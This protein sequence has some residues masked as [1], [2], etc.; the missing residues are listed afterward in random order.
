M[1]QN[2]LGIDLSKEWLDI[3]DPRSG[4]DSRCANSPTA[5]RRFLSRLGP[6][7]VIVFEATS[8]CDGTL[9]KLADEGGQPRVRLNPLH[10]WH[11]AQS[12]NLP[13][14]D[15]VDGEP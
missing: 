4:E 13:K 11:F 10:A 7:D 8:G 12:L 14:T 5:I 15:R 3:H 9:L 1:T 6:E 2:Y